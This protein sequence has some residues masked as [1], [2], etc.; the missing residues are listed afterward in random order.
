VRVLGGA[1]AARRRTRSDLDP[2]WLLLF[3]L[4]LAGCAGDGSGTGATTQFDVLQRDVF[5]TSCISGACHNSQTLA[6]GLNLAPGLSWAQLVG[7]EPDNLVARQQ[8]YLRVVPFQPGGSF[9]VRKLGNPGLGEGE[10][11]PLGAGPLSPAQIQQ[12]VAWI[13]A[14]APP[15]AGP[16]ATVTST[17][18]PT[19]TATPTEVPSATATPS[20]T[21]APTTTPTATAVPPTVTGTVPP[22]ATPTATAMATDTPTPSATPTVTATLTIAPGSTLPELQAEIFTPRCAVPACHTDASAAFNGDLSLQ[23]DS[24]YGELVGVEPQNFFARRD[25]L[26][27]VDPGQPDNSFLVRKVTAPGLGEGSLMP[28]SGEPLSAAEVERIRAWIDRGALPDG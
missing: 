22:S 8:G 15:G 28:L 20:A 9:L 19:A 10:R 11:M 26:L 23:A 5:N 17:V 6:G 4:A 1:C 12:V 16:T 7:V 24:S 18:A 14:G 3:A 27:R 25:G 13:E 2:G 21:T